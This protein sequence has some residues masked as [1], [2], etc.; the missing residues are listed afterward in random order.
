MENLQGK[1]GKLVV[2]YIGI[3]NI[4]GITELEIEP[5][6]ITQINGKNGQGKT[7]VLKALRS[8]IGGGHDATLLKNGEDEGEVVVVFESGERI[9][10][11]IGRDK[12][13]MTFKDSNGERVPRGASLLKDITDMIGINPVRLLDA[14]NKD[15]TRYLLD[16][17]EI[18]TPFKEIEA[19]TGQKMNHEDIRHAMQ[20][21]DGEI[22]RFYEYR[23]TIN[24]YGKAKKVLVEDMKASNP[25]ITDKTDWS[26]EQE[27]LEA[28]LRAELLVRDTL[29]V[30]IEAKR[31]KDIEAV[32]LS[33]HAEIE[34]MRERC[35]GIIEKHNSGSA[36]K[37][38]QTN[39][40]SEPGISSLTG[41]ISEAKTKS[42]ASIK[43]QVGIEYVAK[44]EN[45]LKIMRA[46]S[47]N[48]TKKLKGLED[49]KV[50]LLKNL[51]VKGLEIKKGEI[52][53]D[54]VAFDSVNKAKRVLFALTIAG[55]RGGQLPIVCIDDIEMLD[56]ESM[57]IFYKEAL[58]TEMQFFVTKV[59]DDK[60]LTIKKE[61]IK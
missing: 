20:V 48:L 2:S 15:R 1:G 52:F 6:K 47:E 19:V 32:T 3:K 9:E 33:M 56:S 24:R 17:I 58:K 39:T 25:F 44:G 40:A 42:D 10:K 57:E 12:S 35:N 46:D 54:G 8:A 61:V 43:S 13:D 11:K 22:E 38:T 34:A 51:P 16:A 37:V 53:L 60:N 23:A 5:G 36:E 45:D 49:I 21:I 7:S 27:R 50:A 28:E 14:N 41:L 18:K 4:M 29:L 55:L 26:I 59:S 30:S 31:Q